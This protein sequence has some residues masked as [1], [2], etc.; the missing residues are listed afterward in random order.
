[1]PELLRQ[2]ASA[3]TLYS[4]MP[5]HPE[6]VD[7]EM[8]IKNGVEFPF[9]RL[10]G[11][12]GDIV[13][14][15]S[16]LTRVEESLQRAGVPENTFVSAALPGRR[17]LEVIGVMN[18]HG[19]LNKSCQPGSFIMPP[20]LMRDLASG[21]VFEPVAGDH[22]VKQHPLKIID[23]ADYPTDL[24]QPLFE[25]LRRHKNFRA[26]WI[27]GSP[28]PALKPGLTRYQLLVLMDPRDEDIFHELNIVSQNACYETA[29]V[30]L[31]RLDEKDRAYLQSFIDQVP[32][33]FYAA[34]DFVTKPV[35]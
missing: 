22:P 14:V 8:V 25:L 15:F 10:Q 16:S 29:E 12:E 18:F 9:V 11:K 21:K 24:V 4:L 1:M 35:I 20:D 5:Y 7:G 13:P 6:V 28:K 26:A 3:E 30:H 31:S 17:M 33:P 32:P 19:E 23:P 2:L 27:F 34:P